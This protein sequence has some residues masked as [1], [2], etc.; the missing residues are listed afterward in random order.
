MGTQEDDALK[1]EW[2][3]MQGMGRALVRQRAIAT[4][5]GMAIV[6]LGAA[7]SVVVYVIWPLHRIPVWVLAV[8]VAIA[9]G[10]AW[11]VRNKLWP[12][13]QFR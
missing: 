9:I 12:G 3:R 2:Q 11:A 13:G 4:L 10:P 1:A 5:A 6:G 7:I 8:P